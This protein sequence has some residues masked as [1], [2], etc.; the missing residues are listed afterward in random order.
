MTGY[1]IPF[2]S[3]QGSRISADEWLLLT[4][5]DRPGPG[6]PGGPY[7]VVGRDVIGPITVSTVWHGYDAHRVGPPQI[8]ETLVS[9][10]NYTEHRHPYETE[11]D[12]VEG[13]AEHVRQAQGVWAGM[14]AANDFLGA[15]GDL[16]GRPD[17][18]S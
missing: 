6:H 10:P 5:R 4:S 17:E 3:R 12:A 11:A 2:Y 18:E 15:L 13:H 1:E 9:A 8:Y 14:Q 7:R 16:L